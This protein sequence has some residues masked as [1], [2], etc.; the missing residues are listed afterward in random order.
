MIGQRLKQVAVFE[1][2]RDAVFGVAHETISMLLLPAFRFPR[3]NDLFAMK[4]FKIS[5][6]ALSTRFDLP[7]NLS[8]ATT[9]QYPTNPIGRW[10]Y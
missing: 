2:I 5:T 6:N 9:S 7:G 8:N 3:E 10:H 1:H 4:F